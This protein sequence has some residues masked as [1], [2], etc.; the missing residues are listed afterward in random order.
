MHQKLNEVI[1][2]IQLNTGFIVFFKLNVNG[3]DNEC[4]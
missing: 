2:A 4:Y 1:L 3:A